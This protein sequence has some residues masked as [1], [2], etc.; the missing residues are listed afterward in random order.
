MPVPF[1]FIFMVET[2]IFLN[3]SMSEN[4]MPDTRFVSYIFSIRIKPIMLPEDYMRPV[5]ADHQ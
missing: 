5:S 3:C 2:L 1:L 4:E